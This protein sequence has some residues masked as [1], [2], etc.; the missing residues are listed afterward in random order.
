MSELVNYQF[1][2]GIAT[3]VMDDGKANVMSVAMLKALNGALNQAEADRAVV[4]LTGR[5]SIFSGGFDLAVF[6]RDKA[7][8]VEMLE[9]GAQLSERLMT[10]PRPV[11]AACNGHAVAMGA[12]LLL[13]T[14]IRI[15]VDQGAKFHVNELIV[16][17]TVPKV[18]VE[19]CRQ[20]LSPAH[21]TQAVCT[22]EPYSPQMALEAGFLDQ[23]TP[24]DTLQTEAR[25]RAER[26][27]KLDAAAFQATKSRVRRPALEAMRQAFDE[28]LI[29][30]Q[31]QFLDH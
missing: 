9:A 6:K 28:D 30:W 17:L 10:F 8:L 14:D 13:S 5:E 3:L 29:G 27:L 23:L 1:T 11:I 21:L 7:E 18:F 22:A 24:A 4:I 25:S 31:Q 12:F 19:V 20:R 2:D 16:G 26:L 15:G